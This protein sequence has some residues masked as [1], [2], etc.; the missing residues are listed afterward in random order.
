MN[1]C[2]IQ[3]IRITKIL[4]IL[5]SSLVTAKAQTIQLKTRYS[6]ISIDGK[7]FI[8]SIK[9]LKT[10]KEYHPKGYSSALMTLA[11][12]K[13]VIY[14]VKAV[15]DQKQKLITLNYTNGSIA[16]VKAEQKNEYF[17]FQLLSLSK[18]KAIDNI[19]WGPYKTNI[20]KTIGDV[21]GV[22]RDDD[23]AIGMLG[24][25][26]NTTGGPPTGGDMSFMYYF[27]HSPDP[28]KYPLPPH[29]KEGQTFTI[30]GDGISDVAFY[31][32]PEEYFRMNYGNGATLEPAFGSVICMHSRDRRK[33]QM[34]RFPVLPDNLDG[35]ANSA[36]YQLVLPTDAGF[37]GSAMALYACPDSLGLKTIEKI[38]LKEGLPHPEIDGKWIKDPKSYRP[39]IA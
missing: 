22:V 10:N 19:I 28:V 11:N 32:R 7:G 29:L 15:Y 37:I 27:I 18:E 8:Q 35:K 21:L 17:R 12:G 20:S 38:V 25:D 26:D 1:H 36:R 24:L 6:A 39:D 2:N 23:F 30:G 16:K 33:E 3:L 34:I 31:S 14:P 9:D 5:F 4:I 13:T